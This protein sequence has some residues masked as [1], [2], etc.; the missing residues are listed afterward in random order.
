METL[1]TGYYPR[2]HDK[3][4]D[5]SMWYSGY[6]QTYVERDVREI[7]NVG[8]IETFGRLVRL[9][10]GRNG[11]LLNPRSSKPASSS[12]FCGRITPASA[13]V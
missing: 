4:L 5:P 12:S 9:C 2:I 11:Q 1:L 13:S 6:Y 8:D 7:V 10:A 3:G